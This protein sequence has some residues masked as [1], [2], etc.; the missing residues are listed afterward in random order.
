[1]LSTFI[2]ALREGLEAALIV[3]ILV[4]YIVRTDRRHLLKP[5]WTGVGVAIAASLALGAVLSFTSAELTDRGEELFAGTTSFIAVGLVTWMVFWMKRTA[6]SLRNELHGKVDSAL[7][8]G[9]VSLALVAFFAVAREGL[10]TALFIYT[11]FKTVG[12]ASTA[13]IGLILGLA[14]AVVLGYLIYN[15]SVKLNL[16]KFFTITGVA[17]IIVAAGVLS[18]GIHEFQELGWI[19][20]ADNFLWDV[21]PWIAKESILGSLLGGTVGFDTTTSFIQFIAWAGYLVAVLVP[22]L[23]KAK[24]VV[25]AAEPVKA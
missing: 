7:T 10:E 6:R 4:A 1:M 19:P 22:Y 24:P 2:I 12:A 23:A 16:S 20:G 21:T 11:N 13:T 15:R 8:G 3:G 5:L 18:Y 25:A 14:L 9:P 17:L